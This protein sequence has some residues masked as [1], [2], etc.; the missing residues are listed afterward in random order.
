MMDSRRS[1]PGRRGDAESGTLSIF[2]AIC[3]SALL[4][5]AGLVLDGGGRLRAIEHDDA[6]AREAARAGGQQIDQT[7]LLQGRGLQ[8]DQAKARAKALAYLAASGVSPRNIKVTMTATVVTVTFE[9]SY[10]TAIIGLIGLNQ[11]TVEGVGQARLVPGVTTA[12]VP[13]AP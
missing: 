6:L 9:S 5:L 11:L 2:I 12:A 13:P 1:G 8:L 3:A 7:A 10:T 4:L